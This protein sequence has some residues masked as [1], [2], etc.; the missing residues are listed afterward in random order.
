MVGPGMSYDRMITGEFIADRGD[1][2]SDQPD[3]PDEASMF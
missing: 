1:A 3:E 2:K